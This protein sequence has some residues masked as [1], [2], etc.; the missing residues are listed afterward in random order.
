MQANDFHAGDLFGQIQ[1]L[2]DQLEAE[3]TA[4]QAVEAADAVKTGL[5]EIVGRE[6]R[7][8]ME[9]VAKMAD[10]LLAGPVSASQRREVETLAQSARRLLVSLNEVL[11]FSHLET[12]EAELTIERFDLHGLVKNAASVLQSR[13]SAKGLTSGIDM[14]ANCPRFIVGDEVRV[15]QVLL[16]LIEAALQST[17]QGSIRLYV[18]V[19]DAQYPLTVRFDITDTGEGFSASERDGLFQPSADT[20]RVGGGLGLPIA[21]RL[22]EAM[23]GDVGCDSVVGQG[24]LYW[25]TF[26]TVVADDMAEEGL[27][28]GLEAANDDMPKPA[29]AAKKGAKKSGAK[30]ALSGHVLVVEG[31]TVNRLL[32]GAYLEDFG[33]THEVVETGTAALMCLASRTYD[34][35]LMDTALPDYDGTQLAQRIRALQAPSSEVPVVALAALADK[36]DG[37]QLV[38]AG[39]NARVAKPIQGRALYAALVPFL[40]AQEDGVV[41]ALAS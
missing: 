11:E 12:G 15:R 6:V 21:R 14:A 39:V 23:G 32:I 29:V 2:V 27:A 30:G 17:V 22:A 28:V 10:L 26:Q 9:S 36:D 4:R 24:T 13:A 37:Q 31:N 3:R 20:S 19:N 38:E 1:N 33:L 5:L 8:P 41:V 25:F 34:L 40:P 35:I 18:S 7:A 16:G